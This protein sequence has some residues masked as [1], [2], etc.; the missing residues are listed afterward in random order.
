MPPT[1]NAPLPNTPAPAA[2]APAGAAS[3]PTPVL[4][5]A[6]VVSA[7]QTVADLRNKI[8]AAIANNEQVV[9][10]PVPAGSPPG[11]QPRRVP[12]GPLITASGAAHALALQLL[13]H[14]KLIAPADT[15]ALAA[16]EKAISGK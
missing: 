12:T 7:I 9:T 2:P 5:A 1:P 8:Q 14:L 13:G 11:T 6:D 15:A 3:A 4:A 16:A 10:L